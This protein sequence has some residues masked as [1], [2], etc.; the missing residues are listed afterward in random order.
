MTPDEYCRGKAAASG[1]SFYYSF[2]YL[3][4]P[5]RAAMMA[6]YAYCREIDDV[7]DEVSDPQI[8][9]KT[10]A[11]WEQEVDALY[12]GRASHPV[13]RAL[14]AHIR[15]MHLPKGRFLAILD[16]MRMDLVV[17]R[18]PDEAALMVYFDRVAGAVGQIAARIFAAQGGRS[19]AGTGASPGD[20][21][22]PL[23]GHTHAPEADAPAWLDRYARHLGRA[24]QWVNVIR[25]I[26]EDARRGRIYLPQA[27]LQ[28]AKL[29]EHQL[30]RLQGGEALAPVLARA[31]QQARC[32]FALAFAALP[33]Q[34]RRPQRPGLIMAAIYADILKC[35]EEENFQVL[36][37]RISITPIRKLWLAWRTW[38]SAAPPRI[39]G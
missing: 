24:L 7:V 2:V 31:A 18:Y 38:L 34:E 25:D 39:G 15:A 27:W 8:A 22:E 11:W 1:S 5:T 4:D 28:E 35:M 32:E 16:G 6:L 17:K 23:A 29:S 14:A 36:H 19:P 21:P 20:F 33:D 3:R 12:E 26:G 10:L 30:I 37:Q 9:E 13:T